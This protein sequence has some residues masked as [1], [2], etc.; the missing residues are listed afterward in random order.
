MK[1]LVL[2]LIATTFTLISCTQSEKKIETSENPDGSL[3]TTTIETEKSI[4]PDSAKIN[5][6]LDKAKEKL[7]VAGE[8]I[9]AAA[10]KA[11]EKL[12]QAGKDVKEAADRGAK[13]VEVKV[14]SVR[15][16]EEKK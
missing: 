16:K 4:H 3:T 2:S 7:E 12:E 15:T 5:A 1:S 13:K 10:E 8:K 9:D 14:E 11:G 6:T